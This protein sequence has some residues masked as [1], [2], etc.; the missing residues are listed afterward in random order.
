MNSL[1]EALP[2]FAISLVV[3]AVFLLIAKGRV[4]AKTLKGVSM[5]YA[6]AVIVIVLLLLQSGTPPRN[7]L[8][9]EESFAATETELPEQKDLS[10]RTLT[11]EE[12]SE[13][14]NTL[15]EEQKDK[16]SVSKPDQEANK[17]DNPK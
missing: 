13:R 3:F 14:L 9:V 16:V 12:S 17:D 10:P 1:I 4:S 6:G 5:V 15:I 2:E 7:T 11:S 8:E